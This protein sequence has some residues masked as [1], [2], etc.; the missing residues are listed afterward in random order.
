[1]CRE[2]RIVRRLNMAQQGHKSR[3]HEGLIPLPRVVLRHMN[4]GY[5]LREI[6]FPD[7]FVFTRRVKLPTIFCKTNVMWRISQLGYLTVDPNIR[8]DYSRDP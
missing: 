1:M 4:P 7:G 2:T 6:T 5:Y 3:L 8:V